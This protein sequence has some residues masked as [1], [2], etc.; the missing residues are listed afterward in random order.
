MKRRRFIKALAAA[1]AVP[2]LVAQQAAPQQP[3]RRTQ[4]EIAQLPLTEAGAIADPVARFFT[5]SQFAALRKLSGILVRPL[6]AISGRSTAM[7]RSLSIFWFPPRPPIDNS[8]IAMAST[9]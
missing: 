2:A 3:G 7:R 1:P 9:P 5:P 8:F 4:Q 6:P